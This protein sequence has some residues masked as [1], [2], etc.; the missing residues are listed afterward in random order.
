MLT[1]WCSSTYADERGGGALRR[2][3]PPAPLA[4]TFMQLI[5]PGSP[6]RDIKAHNPRFGEMMRARL[7]ELSFNYVT[8]ELTLASADWG[9]DTGPSEQMCKR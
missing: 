8:S 2:F 9:A 4:E 7:T 6:Y 3:S 5:K 1:D